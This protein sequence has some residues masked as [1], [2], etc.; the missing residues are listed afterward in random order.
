ML[1][2]AGLVETQ[3]LLML[4]LSL[5][6]LRFLLLLLLFVVVFDVVAAVVVQLASDA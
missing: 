5:P 1:R 3:E 2:P 4:V 6:F